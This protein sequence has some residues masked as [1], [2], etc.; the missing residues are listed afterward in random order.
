MCNTH[1]TIIGI[2]CYFTL[3][4]SFFTDSKIKF[5]C[6][7]EN[8][9]P[10]ILPWCTQISISMIFDKNP[11]E[12]FKIAT[13]C[14]LCQN[15]RM[16]QFMGQGFRQVKPSSPFPDSNNSRTTWIIAQYVDR[17]LTYSC[18]LYEVILNI[19]IKFIIL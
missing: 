17:S 7:K 11:F 10:A 19:N 15:R 16:F 13:A 4:E 12:T 18:Y 6:I 3:S 1:A 5:I 14:V 9:G 8:N 2:S